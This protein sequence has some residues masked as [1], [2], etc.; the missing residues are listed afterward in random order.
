L[1][2][3]PGPE[4]LTTPIPYIEYLSALK[5]LKMIQ[6]TYEPYPNDLVSELWLE[7]ISGNNVGYF[8]IVIASILGF[9]EGKE[10]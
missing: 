10:N 6:L 7:Y 2:K 4:L 9:Y 8:I 1:F 5:L 3:T